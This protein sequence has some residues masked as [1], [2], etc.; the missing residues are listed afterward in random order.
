MNTDRILY[1]DRNFAVVTKWVG[2]VC[3]SLS[4]AENPY[5]DGKRYISLPDSLKPVIE[6]SLG[7][8]IDFCQ[9]VNRLD[10]TVISRVQRKQHGKNVHGSYRKK[11]RGFICWGVA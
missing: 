4:G 5:A 7:Q 1:A 8:K 3:E 11:S 10:T 9:C 6:N 2:E